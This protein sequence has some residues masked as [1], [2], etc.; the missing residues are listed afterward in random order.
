[1]Y[2]APISDEATEAEKDIIDR[3]IVFPFHYS[4]D[5]GVSST[6]HL[7]KASSSV[8]LTLCTPEES[9]SR[10]EEVHLLST[11]QALWTVLVINASSDFASDRKPFQHLTPIAQYIRGIASSLYTQRTNAQS[12]YEALRDEL[13]DHDGENIFDDEKFTKSI[14]YHWAVKTCDELSE[15]ISSSLRFIERA[16]DT[17]VN[18]LCMEA[19]ASERLGV[20]F[21]LQQLKEEIFGLTDLQAQ[22]RAMSGRVQ[23]SVRILQLFP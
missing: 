7:A 16:L 12:I 17:Q 21:W 13:E 20:K 3:T 6:R 9:L 8:L 15:S 18:K 2:L 14:S 23:E 11:P 22:I 19:H 4:K 1:M 10:E 5:T